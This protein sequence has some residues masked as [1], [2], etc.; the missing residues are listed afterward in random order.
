MTSPTSIRGLR[1]AIYAVPD[2]A[3]AKAWYTS[4]LERPPYFDEE[5]YVGYNVGG[6]ELGLV[7]EPEAPAERDAAGVAFW[8]VD[9]AEGAY[10]RLVGLGAADHEPVQDVGGGVRIGAVRDPFGNILGVV[11]NPNFRIEG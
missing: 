8:G 6:F 2:L 1:T 9:D 3:A 4:A 10:A 7:P 5:F 11:Q